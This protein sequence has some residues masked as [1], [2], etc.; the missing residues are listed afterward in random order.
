VID[1]LYRQLLL[2]VYKPDSFGNLSARWEQLAA[3]E[4]RPLAENR[5]LQW[6]KVQRMVAHAYGTTSFYR[7]RL[8]AAGVNAAGLKSPADLAKIPPLTR[9]DIRNRKDALLSSS[10]PQNDLFGAATGGTTE[11]PVP[12][13]R[14]R[15]CLQTRNADQMRLNLWA[16]SG[17]SAKIFWLWGAAVDFAADPSWR[18][19]LWERYVLRHVYAPSSELNREICE[20]YRQRL[21]AFRPKTII[22]YPTPLTIFAE[23]LASSGKDYW[24]PENIIVTAEPLS[25]EQRRSIEAAFGV[26]PYLQYGARDFGMIASECEQHQGLHYNPLAVYLEFEPIGDGVAEVLVTD[27]T[28]RAMPMIRYKV[29]DCAMPI[30]AA[31]PCGRGF[32]RMTEVVGRTVDNFILPNGSIVPGVALTN[33]VLKDFA[34]LKKVQIIQQDYE[35]FVVRYVPGPQFNQAN[36]ANTA[37]VMRKFVGA[38]ARIAF[39]PVD[40]IARERSGKTRLCISHVQRPATE[41]AAGSARGGRA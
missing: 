16:G 17:P 5:A 35:D 25:A 9:E 11:S 13:Y 37:E 8:D 39:V 38:T 14:D 2:P 4:S 12:L 40:D 23:Y 36:L 3:A 10:Y 41:N 19:R 32:P 29:G 1:L 22:A 27:L 33:R 30:E 6:K 18:W 28:N 34:V 20:T 24:R 21:N 15:A 31:C 7:E 26:R